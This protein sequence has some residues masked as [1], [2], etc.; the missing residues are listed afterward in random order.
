MSFTLP[1]KGEIL[2]L[3]QLLCPID[4][5]M[6]ELSTKH[7]VTIKMDDLSETMQVEGDVNSIIR[8]FVDFVKEVK[9]QTYTYNLEGLLDRYMLE[10][11]LEFRKQ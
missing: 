4:F 7:K 1:K 3:K 8:F 11:D 6:I 9:I 5:K 10:A 2:N